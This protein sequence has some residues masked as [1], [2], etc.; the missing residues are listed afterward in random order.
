ME[1]E[2]QLISDGDGLAIIGHPAAVD[3]FLTTERLPSKDLGLK[4][5]SSA[6]G[7]GSKIAK[8]GAEIS[9]QSGRWVQLSAES[10]QAMKKYNLMSGSEHGLSRAVLTDHGRITGL[11]EIV[12]TP[13]AMLTNPA[14]LTGAAGL[15]AQLAMKQSM[16]EITDYLAVIDA[17]VD[18]V[19]R[20]QTD[21]VM[22]DMIG[23]ELVIDEALTIREQ[24]GRVSE[25]TWSKVQATPVPL[26]RTQAYALRQ[27][28]AIA[29]N[30]ETTNVGD[31]AA[32][33]KQA[34]IK[35]QEWLAVLARCFQL[36]D[37]VAVL[38]LDRVLDASAEES[39]EHRV[40]IRIAR[41]K[42][43]ELISRTT[44]RLMAR[45]DTA[46]GTANAKVL[47]NPTS[48]RAVVRSTNHVATIV[49]D[50]HGRL[51]IERV[52][53]SWDA[54]RWLDAAVEVRDKVV[55]TGSEV[56]AKVLD[57]GAEV[58]DKVVETGAEGVG[59]AS[60]F[61]M[62]AFGRAK[63]MMGRVPG[64]IA[65]RAQRQLGSSEELDREQP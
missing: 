7:T 18:A 60:R 36:Q 56:G 64:G 4:R 34:E 23:V 16:D 2:I 17:K 38:E 10:A 54:R 28:D 63:S 51:G 15:M 14:I 48:S 27:L 59:V 5:L 32:T 35:V 20:T 45:M 24:V 55:E 44:E 33:S 61:S 3:R 58:K 8:V 26:A 9:E 49:V 52:R 53:R 62:Q 6:L 25:V 65:E 29:E 37:A 42:R 19:L 30:L 12:Q 21:A 41:Q 1:N 13:S 39:E 43:L 31:L 57:T 50:F 22:A 47:F 40:A 11:L 46:A